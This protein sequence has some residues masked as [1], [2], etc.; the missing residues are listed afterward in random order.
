MRKYDSKGNV[1]YEI[2]STCEHWLK[3]DENNNEI[4]W[5][6]SDGHERWQEYDENNRVIYGRTKSGYE[7]WNEYDMLGNRID[8]PKE[9]IV[10]REFLSRK[11]ISRFELM[12]IE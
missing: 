10:E 8:I 12:D 5:R 11:L 4:Y 7:W 2:N 3:Y 6:R 9:V 1:I